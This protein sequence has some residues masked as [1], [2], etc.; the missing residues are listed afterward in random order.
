MPVIIWK[1]T[2]IYMLFYCDY[3]ADQRNGSKTANPNTSALAK[4]CAARVLDYHKISKMAAELKIAGIDGEES[5]LIQFGGFLAKNPEKRS[6]L[7]IQMVE[8]A[9]KR[10]DRK[11]PTISRIIL[12]FSLM[13]SLYGRACYQLIASNLP[14]ASF[15]HMQRLSASTADRCILDHSAIAVQTRLQ[16]LV[17]RIDHDGDLFVSLSMDATKIVPALVSLPR[18]GCIVG[19]KSPEHIRAINNDEEVAEDGLE[20]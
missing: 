13:L 12:D 17:S 10:D 5:F 3:I 14:L 2:N 8:L 6:S 4:S 1:F 11:N 9:I 16:K 7:L 20:N 19:L 15:R 18:F